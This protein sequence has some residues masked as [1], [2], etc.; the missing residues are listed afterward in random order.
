[1]NVQ[2]FTTDFTFQQAPGSNP[3]GDGLAFV[4][5]NAS[6]AAQGP[7]GGG[8]GYGPGLAAQTGGGIGNSI[9]I[10]F[11]VYDNS[12][13]G[14]NS[15]GLYTNGASPTTP[16]VDLTASGVNLHLGNIMRAHVTYN[17]TTLVLTI[18]DTSSGIS[19]TNSWN[20][21]IPTTINSNTAYAGFT[22][23]TGGVTAVQ[24]SSLGRTA[25]A[26]PKLPSTTQPRAFPRPAPVQPSLLSATPDSLTARA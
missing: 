15:T 1:V 17:G 11:D 4:L 16:A 19:F 12:G 20:I 9:A 23:G 22:D 7:A 8:L 18:S 3:T 6:P 21:N 26:L 24:E 25:P 14:T 10:K 5:Q 2:A 13:E